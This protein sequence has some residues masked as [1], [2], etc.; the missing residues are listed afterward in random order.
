MRGLLRIG[1]SLVLRYLP[2]LGAAG[3]SRGFKPL[4]GFYGRPAGYGPGSGVA[5]GAFGMCLE[6]SLL[7]WW[8]S[9]SGCRQSTVPARGDRMSLRSACRVQRRDPARR[10]PKAPK[11]AAFS[12]TALRA[13]PS[14]LVGVQPAT[15]LTPRPGARARRWRSAARPCL[16]RRASVVSTV[17][18]SER[19]ETTLGSS[20]R[21]N[22]K[23]L[24]KGGLW[25][26]N[27]Q[28]WLFWAKNARKQALQNG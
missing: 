20:R 23:P 3:D 1:S 28:K 6:A 17:S 14:A 7:W 16:P 10:L 21:Q 5:C 18:V 27:W 19:V 11:G 2:R 13:L 24:N 9:A 25:T 4:P 22:C 15:V 8:L 26:S 12:R